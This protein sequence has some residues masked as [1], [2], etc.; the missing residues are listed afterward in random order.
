MSKDRIQTELRLEDGK[1]GGQDKSGAVRAWWGMIFLKDFSARARG[2]YA[3][4]R[5]RYPLKAYQ[6]GLSRTSR[7]GL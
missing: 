5:L 6:V 7:A 4:G 2:A 1:P 3:A